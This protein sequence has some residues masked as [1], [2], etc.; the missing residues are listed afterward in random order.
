MKRKLTKIKKA[1]WVVVRLLV[2]MGRLNPQQINR[3]K[4][5]VMTLMYLMSKYGTD[6]TCE[7]ITLIRA[8]KE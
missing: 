3:S 2:E 6:K 8:E 4:E 5:V 1:D 7:A